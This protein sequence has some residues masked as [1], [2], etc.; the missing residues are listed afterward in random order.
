MKNN[1]LKSTNFQQKLKALRNLKYSQLSS[2]NQWIIKILALGFFTGLLSIFVLYQSVRL[3]AFG[4]VPSYAQLKKIENHVASE[5]YSIDNQVLGRYFLQ[6]RTNVKYQD[7]PTHFVKILVATEDERFYKHHGVDNWSLFRVLFKSILLRNKNTGGGSTISQ[8]L[9]KN[10]FPRKSFGLFSMPVNKCR[11][12]ITAKRFERIYN[13]KEVLTLYL[14]T[15]PFGEDVYGLNVAAKRFY[16][17]EPKH[18]TVE[19]SA[20]LVGMLQ[21]PSSY[22]P[23]LHPQRAKFRRNIVFKQMLKNEVIN[24]SQYNQ[25]IKFP[26][27]IDYQFLSHS[28]GLAPHF[29]AHLSQELKL[30]CKNYKK[31]NGGDYNIYTDGLKITTTIHSK[32]QR[33]AEEAVAEQL[34][35]LQKEFAQHWKG[36]TLWKASDPIIQRAKKQTSRYKTLKAQGKSEAAINQSFSTPT[37]MRLFT[38]DNEKEL[39]MS[40]MDSIIHYHSLLNAGFI[41]TD[42][43][44]GQIRAWV[45]GISHRYLKYDNLKMQRQA[46]SVF[47]PILYTSALLNDYTPCSFIENEKVIFPEF[48]NWSPDN[49]NYKYG[50]WY[51]LKGG[52]A[53]SVNTVAANLIQHIG[54][55]EVVDLAKKMGIKSKLTTTP[56]L[57]LGATEV[58]LME[59]A[60]AYGV[61]ANRGERVALNYIV[62]IEDA[63]GNV[64]YDDK[65]EERVKKTKIFAPHIA[66]QMNLMLQGVVDS[67]TARSL[68]YKYD[69]RSAIAGKTGTTQNQADGRFVGFTPKMVGVS[70]VGGINQ[71]VRFRNLNLGS[72]GHTALPI[73]AR[74]Y[75]KILQDKSFNHWQHLAFKAES[76]SSDYD[77]PNFTIGEIEEVI[78]EEFGDSLIVEKPN[79]LD[80][81]FKKQDTKVIPE[82]QNIED[83]RLNEKPR[84]K[85]KSK[86]KKKKNKL[87]KWWKKQRDKLKR[88]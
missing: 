41:A 38:W 15:V 44:S 85:K 40:P 61:F 34:A 68:R 76:D 87:Q 13:K 86:K 47:K 63:K 5:V 33:Y 28:D 77:C 25:L 11:E 62:K 83:D 52:L 59:L 4:G 81:L 50:G 36:K 82:D 53:N 23:R 22:N 14:N 49:A 17:I 75:K 45:G 7:I 26:L 84:K 21:S 9:A 18:L 88:G 10:L 32:W 27:K 35:I 24:T 79:L 43:Q 31:E 42:P 12:I 80:R 16:N 54:T 55:E 57:A 56:A 3:G 6:N 70:W 51:T 65:K 1:F 2:R 71:K 46:G 64:L 60:E 78:D 66:D 29:R 8:Q 67:G 30:F 73:W 48:Q 39:T 69:L 58:N 72:G 37:R 74:F 20:V 19:Q